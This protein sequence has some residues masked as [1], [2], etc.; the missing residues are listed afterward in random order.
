MSTHMHTRDN[1]CKFSHPIGIISY[2]IIKLN[3][4]KVDDNDRIFDK[5]KKN[6]RNPLTMRL[7]C[8]TKIPHYD[9]YRRYY[10]LLLGP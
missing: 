1:L 4:G 2:V 7:K 6:L 9:P 3:S 8:R 5:E 10:I